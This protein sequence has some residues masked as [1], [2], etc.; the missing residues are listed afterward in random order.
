MQQNKG[1]ALQAAEKLDFG[2]FCIRA[3]LSAAADADKANRM[4]G[5]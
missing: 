3:R 1:W 4:N 2:P 5:L